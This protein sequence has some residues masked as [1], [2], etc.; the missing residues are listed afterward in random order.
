[1]ELLTLDK[2][3]GAKAMA[4]VPELLTAPQAAEYLGVTRQAVNL[5]TRRP[6]PG[7][8]TRYGAVWMF[9]KAELDEW[10][11]R[12]RTHGG[13]PPGSKTSAVIPSPVIA[14]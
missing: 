1:M 13:R 12:P 10:R 14:V 9:T 3:G 11:T 7:L 5:L 6:Y 8:G 2:N 4:D